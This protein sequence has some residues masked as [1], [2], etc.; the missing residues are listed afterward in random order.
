MVRCLRIPTLAPASVATNE[1]GYP[2]PANLIFG[3]NR[4]VPA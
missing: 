4:I 3:L 1:L 2:S